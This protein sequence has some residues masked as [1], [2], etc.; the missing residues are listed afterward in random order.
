MVSDAPHPRELAELTGTL[1]SSSDYIVEG[2]PP[3]VEAKRAGAFL[4]DHDV[5]PGN[6]D[7]GH[8]MQQVRLGVAHTHQRH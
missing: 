7:S 1:A 3:V 8:F 4:G 6:R 2:A 5:T